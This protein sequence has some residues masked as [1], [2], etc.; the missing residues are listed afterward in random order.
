ML[1]F[2][3]PTHVII[4]ARCI[5]DKSTKRRLWCPIFFICLQLTSSNSRFLFITRS[6][7]FKHSITH[8]EGEGNRVEIPAPGS[9]YED[10]S[11]PLQAQVLLETSS[12]FFLLALPSSSSKIRSTW[13]IRTTYKMWMNRDVQCK[14]SR[15]NGR[16]RQRRIM[17]HPSTV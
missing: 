15:E 8:D 2:V 7:L 9:F 14:L 17:A 4:C 1:S 5:Q 13:E 16:R 3:R 6:A 12:Q 10:V 11:Q